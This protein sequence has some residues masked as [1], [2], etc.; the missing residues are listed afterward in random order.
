MGPAR[1]RRAR[2]REGPT[3]R[4]SWDEGTDGGNGAVGLVNYAAEAA[5]AAAIVGRLIR[6][7][8]SLLRRVLRVRVLRVHATRCSFVRQIPR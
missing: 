1:A 5:A 8:A 3:S 7:R 2:Q 4:I 6:R